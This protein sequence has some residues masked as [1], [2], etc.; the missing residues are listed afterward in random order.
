MEWRLEGLN[1]SSVKDSL[2]IRPAN[3]GREESQIARR[4]YAALQ[5]VLEI[6]VAVKSLPS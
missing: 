4:G 3:D 5:Y 6:P 2:L 1:E